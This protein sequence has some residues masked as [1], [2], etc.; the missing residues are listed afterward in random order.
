[1]VVFANGQEIRALTLNKNEELDV[2]VNEKRINAIDYDPKMQHI[3]WIDGHDDAIRRSAMIDGKMVQIG[4][5]QDIS[6]NGRRNLQNNRYF[7][8]TNYGKGKN[9]SNDIF[10]KQIQF[11][12]VSRLTGY[13][14]TSTGQRLRI[15]LREST[16]G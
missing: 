11:R 14:G 15:S 16:V 7:L 9:L 8:F 1:M 2:V 10:L 12:R 6:T 13:Q 5:A 3:Y 4:Y